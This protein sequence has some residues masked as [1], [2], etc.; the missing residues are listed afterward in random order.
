MYL[1]QVSWI[2]YQ[3]CKRMFAAGLAA[4]PGREPA[5]ALT[6]Q[7]QRLTKWVAVLTR[8]QQQQQRPTNLVRQHFQQNPSQTRQPKN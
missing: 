7:R 8:Q 6:R 2:P 5:T 4:A 3:S 1:S